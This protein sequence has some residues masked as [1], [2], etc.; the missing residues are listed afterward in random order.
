MIF[1]QRLYNHRKSYVEQL[2]SEKLYFHKA[3]SLSEFL[4][5]FSFRY[6]IDNN[7]TLLFN[8]GP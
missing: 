7:E 4:S 8:F 5:E 2:I 1:K 3:A 6:K